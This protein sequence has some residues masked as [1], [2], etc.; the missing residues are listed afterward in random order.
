MPTPTRLAWID[1]WEKDLVPSEAG[2]RSAARV[3]ARMRSTRYYGREATARLAQPDYEPKYEV[4]H[5]SRPEAQE[6]KALPELKVVTRQTS[7]WRAALLAMVFAGV[8]LGAL[9]VV[10]VLVS[11]AAT[12]LEAEVGRLEV[13]ESELAAANSALYAQISTL[14]SPDRVVEQAVKLGLG[15][16]QSVHYL[17]VDGD[18]QTSSGSAVAEGD[19]TLAGR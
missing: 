8:V 19:T 2:A 9:I 12:G 5:Q 17:E 1:A 3:A 18:L 6:H 13:Q 10:P 4:Q 11:S 16:A 7:R 15:P 14:A